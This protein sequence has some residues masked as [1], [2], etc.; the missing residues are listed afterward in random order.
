MDG[1]V[2]EVWKTVLDGKKEI[3]L[4]VVGG[5]LTA[6]GTIFKK[7]VG[8]F[9]SWIWKWIRRPRVEKPNVVYAQLKT[10]EERDKDPEAAIHAISQPVRLGRSIEDY[11]PPFMHSAEIERLRRELT[12]TTIH[13]AYAASEA[14]KKEARLEYLLRLRDSLGRG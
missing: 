11:P 9:F 4:L 1:I 8:S 13:S 3:I 12:N 10:D 6:M 7:A 5:L 2:G 14:S